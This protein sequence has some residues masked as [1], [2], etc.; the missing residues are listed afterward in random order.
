MTTIVDFNL[1]RALDALLQEESVTRAAARVRITAPAMSRALGRLRI[2]LNDPLLVRAGRELVLTPHARALRGRAQLAA[3]EASDVLR[4]AGV[5]PLESVSRTFVIRCND[6]VG[7]VLVEPLLEAART[8]APGLR[9]RFIPEGDEDAAPLRDGRID[10]DLGV[11]DFAEPEL[12]TRLI[13][14]DGYV[15]VARRGH[16]LTRG[17]VSAARFAAAT[18]VAVSRRG[19]AWGPID[20]ALERLAL[21]RTTAAVVPDF[22]AAL[23]ACASS[24]LVT[25]VPRLL[26]RAAGARLGLVAFDLPVA[27]PRISLAQAWHPRL[28]AEPAH[29]WL[30]ERVHAV[31]ARASTDAS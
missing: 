2:A 30:R 21:Q 7:A 22:F 11:I 20:E 8:H 4:P 29:R 6:A 16:A 23:F 25:A 15:G 13:L 5:T 3:K 24:D 1:L 17:K 28:D 14:R 31:L 18:H 27:T 19:R 26:T 10:L 9:F 12:K